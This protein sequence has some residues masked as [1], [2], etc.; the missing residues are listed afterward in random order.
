[1]AEKAS[2]PSAGTNAFFRSS[3]LPE[4]SGNEIRGMREKS[5]NETV[6]I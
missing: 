6:V 4:A 3:D 2:V 1:M 5:V